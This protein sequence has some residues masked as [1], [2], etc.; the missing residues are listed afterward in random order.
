MSCGLSDLFEVPRIG[1]SPERSALK[2]LTYLPASRDSSQRPFRRMEDGPVEKGEIQKLRAE[3]KAES[4]VNKEERGSV[5]HIKILSRRQCRF[6]HRA[7]AI[8]AL[9]IAFLRS[10]TCHTRGVFTH[11]CLAPIT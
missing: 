2:I 7:L 6:S 1:T 4:K 10:V 3:A 5:S 9:F 8:W 11:A